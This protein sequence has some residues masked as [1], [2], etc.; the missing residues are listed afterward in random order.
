MSTHTYTEP[1]GWDERA[2]GKAAVKER[3]GD[4]YRKKGKG[5][6]WREELEPGGREKEREPANGQRAGKT[7]LDRGLKQ[8][9]P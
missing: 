1:C 2:Q 7:D 8:R 5:S 3:K 4:R 9:G 6:G